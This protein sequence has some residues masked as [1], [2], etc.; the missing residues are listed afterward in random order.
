[1]HRQLHHQADQVLTPSRLRVVRTLIPTI[2]TALYL[3]A[4]A[5]C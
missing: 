5:F 3:L 2:S 4:C 1:M